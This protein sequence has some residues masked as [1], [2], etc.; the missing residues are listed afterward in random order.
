[1]AASI[2]IKRKEKLLM[3]ELST[4]LIKEGYNFFGNEIISIHEVKIS[5]DLSQA[6]IYFST[7][8]NDTKNLKTQLIKN[9][10]IIKKYLAQRIKNKVRKIPNLIFNVSNNLEKSFQI[11]KI[12][13]DIHTE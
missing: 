11:Q 7:L 2:A 1:M 6:H 4:M 13:S 5:P 3:E 8:S 9:E 10:I 12:L